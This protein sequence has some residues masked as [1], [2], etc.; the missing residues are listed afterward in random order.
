MARKYLWWKT[1]EDAPAIPDRIVAQVMNL[2][3]FN[4]VEQL[5]IRFGEEWLRRVLTT[6]APG[7]FDERSWAYWHYRLGLAEP[8]GL[9]EMPARRFT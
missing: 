5:V 8:G 6:A 2:G 4:D 9:P 1:P 7:T 3:D